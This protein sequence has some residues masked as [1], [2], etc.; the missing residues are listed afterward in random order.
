MADID[1]RTVGRRA[2]AVQSALKRAILDRALAPGTK[3]P[4]DSVGEH[5]GVSR[6]LVREALL[7][8]SEEGL[9]EL[10]PNRGAA[11]A[12][13][14][15]EEGHTLFATRIALEKLVVETLSGRL[16]DQLQLELANHIA[17]EETA[18]AQRSPSAARL[19]GEFHVLLAAM[20]GNAT[21]SRYVNELVSRSSL[22]LALH[23]S[24]H[25]P[26]CTASEHRMILAALVAGNN[27]HAVQCMTQHLTRVTTQKLLSK[28]RN[29][30]AREMLTSCPS[31]K[32]LISRPITNVYGDLC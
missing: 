7:R 14:S 18:S 15:R 25:S 29:D 11:V 6:T 27:K 23:G 20:T 9:V 4:E 31:A 32:R 8:L 3:L 24:P 17:A 30:S 22:V 16:T 12:R 19:A 2:L 21:L 26:E 13:P 10:R 5:L 28:K 1:D